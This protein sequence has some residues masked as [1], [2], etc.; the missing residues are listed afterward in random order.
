MDFHYLQQVKVYTIIAW[1]D[2]EMA[3]ELGLSF[4]EAMGC[5]FIWN[6]ICNVQ[7]SINLP[8][9]GGVYLF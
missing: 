9:V 2:P 6:Q 5:S 4:Q 7:R 3:I 1:L 8:N